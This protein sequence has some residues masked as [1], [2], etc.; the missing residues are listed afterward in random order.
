MRRDAMR[1]SISCWH[2]W[3]P[4]T[5]K[6]SRADFHMVKRLQ[7]LTMGSVPQDR[8]RSARYPIVGAVSF[9]WRGVNGRWCEATGLTRDIGKT[10]VFVE[11]ESLPPASS[12]LE[13]AI[14][15]PTL[16]ERHSNLC[17]RGAGIVRYLR[18]DI[19]SWRGYGA[20]IVLHVEPRTVL[21]TTD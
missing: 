10:G 21:R 12:F 16:W 14:T 20:S 1:R 4:T 6:L 11:C 2:D 3:R 8:R 7:E 18:L 15:L 5:V 19:N 13:L 17:L 9:R